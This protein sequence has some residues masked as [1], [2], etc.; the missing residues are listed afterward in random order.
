MCTHNILS[1]SFGGAI[2]HLLSAW[3]FQINFLVYDILRL[4]GRNQFQKSCINIHVASAGVDRG[5]LGGQ[6]PP[7]CQIRKKFK[8][9]LNH[10]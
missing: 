10:H 1:W 9:V 8:I 3:H 7:F 4:V 2:T 6:D 5:G